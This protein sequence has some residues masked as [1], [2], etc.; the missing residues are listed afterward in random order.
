M[1]SNNMN[2][3]NMNT[4]GAENQTPN[5]G[6]FSNQ[7]Q[8]GQ[9]QYSQ[10]QYAQNNQNQYYQVPNYPVVVPG[11]NK[12]VASLVLGIL[13]IVFIWGGFSGFVSLILS[14]IGLILASSAK[15]DGFD[16]GIRTAGFVTSLIGLIGGLLAVLAC[17]ACI[18][19]FGAAASSREFERAADEFFYDFYGRY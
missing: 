8:Y 4:A 7:N 5:Q 10:N 16:E 15:K 19:A 17:V 13:S 6:Q 9:N 1:D 12:A 2:N 18:G 11:K 3:E 14:V